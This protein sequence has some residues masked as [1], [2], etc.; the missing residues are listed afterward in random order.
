MNWQEPLA[1]KNEQ[2]V[3]RRTDD[4]PSK[5][6]EK[7]TS[8]AT[9]P[10]I[11]EL[12]IADICRDEQLQSREVLNEDVINEYAACRSGG[13]EFPPVVVFRNDGKCWLADGFHRVAAEQKIGRPVIACI[14]HAGTKD[15]DSGNGDGTQAAEETADSEADESADSKSEQSGNAGQAAL[16]NGRDVAAQWP[17]MCEKHSATVARTAGRSSSKKVRFIRLKRARGGQRPDS[18]RS[19]LRSGS[20][21]G[22]A[23]S[24]FAVTSTP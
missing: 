14:V 16:D 22:A 1:E 20:T 12:S 3:D 2:I 17:A 6:A 13:D 21:K 19:N 9:A 5:P 15:D 18:R 7:V 10:D 8:G 11:E 24:A 23:P 4:Q